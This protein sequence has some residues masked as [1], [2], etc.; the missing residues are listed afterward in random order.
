[1]CNAFQYI[2][3]N[4]GVDSQSSYGY[5]ARVILYTKILDDPLLFDVH[6]K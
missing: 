1:M 6:M 2:I 4:E 3:A 5:R